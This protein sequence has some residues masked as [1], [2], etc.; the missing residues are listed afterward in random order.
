[1]ATACDAEAKVGMQA[2]SPLEATVEIPSEKFNVRAPSVPGDVFLCGHLPRDV[3][4]EFAKRC[5][6]WIYVNEASNPNF[7]RA[8]IEAAGAQCEVLHFAPPATTDER[9]KELEA[10]LDSLPRP[11]M[12]QC[13][14]GNRAGVALLL[15]LAHHRGYTAKSAEQLALDLRLKFYTECETCGRLRTW[16]MDQ[17]PKEGEAIENRKV[18]DVAIV[19]QL[20]DPDSSTYT[21]II[22][23]RTTGE[24]VLIDPVLEQ[25]DRD[26]KAIDDLGL[27]LKYVL[28]T[29]CHADHVT[30]GG[31]I[32]KE[33]PSVLTVISEASGAKADV[34]V[35]HG[36]DV[37]FGSLKLEVRATPGHTDGCVSYVLRIPEQPAM[38]F[39]GD[40][41][42]IRGCGR[43]DFQQG[44][45]GM[46]YDSVHEQ[47]FSLPPDTLIYPAHDYK[48]R[49][50]ST[51][52]EERKFN[53]RL[54]QSRDSFIEIMANLGLPYPRKIDVAVPAN[55]ACGVQD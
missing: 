43:T 15:W 47:V 21:Y 54:T 52:D 20:F 31:S 53:P 23:C 1:M 2:A 38:C 5:R 36:D 3:V 48:G 25:K 9:V 55:M 29:H 6:S 37:A 22:G 39:T 49:N 26:L 19:E 11:L 17:L 10:A 27:T 40:A 34:H 50:V 30:S 8:E 32:R 45:A 4:P 12:L 46:L 41:L 13:N 44:N 35:K 14:A 33:R 51:V 42:L 18:G 24:A 28:N 16:I 7:F